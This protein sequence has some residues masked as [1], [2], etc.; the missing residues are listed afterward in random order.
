VI[1]C[2][3]QDE[4]LVEEVLAAAVREYTAKTGRQVKASIDKTLYLPAA[5]KEVIQN[6]QKKKNL[7]LKKKTFVR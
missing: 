7:H 2:R 6:R 3:K 4:H 1:N 5:Q